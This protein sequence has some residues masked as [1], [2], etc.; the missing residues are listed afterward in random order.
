MSEPWLAADTA[1]LLTGIVGGVLV[2]VC[3]L[4]GGLSRWLA[5]RG[6]GRPMVATGFV[7][8]GAIGLIG[9]GCGIAAMASAQPTYLWSP[10]LFIGIAVLASLAMGLPGIV[11]RYRKAR[12]RR[13]LNDLAT[14]LVSGTSSRVLA[15]IDSSR[16][17]R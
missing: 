9:V 17:W 14:Q 7:V 1:G 16:R 15:K 3:A 12:Q 2:A 5:R 4:F 6:D 8:L 11:M 10:A 13:D